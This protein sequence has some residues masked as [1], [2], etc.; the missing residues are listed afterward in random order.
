MRFRVR[1]PNGAPTLSVEP[2]ATIGELKHQ[3]SQA[4]GL[5]DFDV[6]IGY[7]P[8]SLDLH[9]FDAATT[10]SDSGLK[11]DG[12][13]LICAARDPQAKLNHPLA[14]T[15][16]SSAPP[17]PGQSSKPQSSKPQSSTSAPNKPLSLSRKPN[18]TSDDPPELPLPSHSGT[19]VLR[20]MPDDNSCLFRA[21]GSAVLGDSLDSMQELRSIVAQ[22]IQAN[23]EL[24][25][26]G[27]LEQ[28]PDEYCKWIQTPDAWGGGIEIA[29]LAQQFDVE[30]A[31]INVQDLRVDRFNEGKPKRIILVYSG[32]HYDTIAVNPSSPPHTRA[33]APP[34]F[35]LKQFDA[36]DDLVV[37]RARELCKILKDRH[38]YT[39]TKGF[40]IKCNTC[41][42]QGTGEKGATQHAAETGHYD[43]G[44]AQ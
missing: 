20:V 4:T 3:I 43:F 34:D 10:I 2:G 36:D 31:S 12:E 42:W 39:D 19:I 17:L 29:I 18:K 11:L 38:Y 35:D 25:S 15:T 27:A 21:V 32:I 22:G 33:D 14:G 16:P 26:E 6:K 13:Q 5:S 40:S 9:Q 7:P 8:Q 1:G 44:E 30:V 28:K 24:Y 41:G 23:P 37:E